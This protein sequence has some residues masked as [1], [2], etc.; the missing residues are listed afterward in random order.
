MGQEIRISFSPNIYKEARKTTVP[1]CNTAP[2]LHPLT[3]YGSPMLGLVWA[4]PH[5]PPYCFRFTLL[6]DLNLDV[7]V[8]VFHFCIAWYKGETF[9]LNKKE[10]FVSISLAS[11]LGNVRRHGNVRHHSL[12]QKTLHRITS[13]SCVVVPADVA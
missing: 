3:P 4:F 6:R 10:R 12:V 2:I 7:H 9:I 1:C 11:R 8:L 5:G 13:V